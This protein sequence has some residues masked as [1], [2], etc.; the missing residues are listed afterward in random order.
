MNSESHS[1]EDDIPLPSWPLLTEEETARQL[2]A[3]LVRYAS[4]PIR[5]KLEV[6]EA[7]IARLQN[8]VNIQQK[9]IER[10]MEARDIE[11]A[12]VQE[13]EDRIASALL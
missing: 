1:P 7:E 6:S 11:K 13:L 5:E 12:K 3:E 9:Q 2:R 4:R 10:L 8:I